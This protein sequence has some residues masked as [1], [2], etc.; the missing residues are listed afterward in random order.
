MLTQAGQQLYPVL[1]DGLDR[2][3]WA[4]THL[5][6]APAITELTVTAINDF[7]SKWLVP[8]LPKFQTTVNG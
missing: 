2:F 1:R 6:N 3:A 7:A 4:I 8:R 5:Q